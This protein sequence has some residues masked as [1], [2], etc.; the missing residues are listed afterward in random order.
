M[1]ASPAA[2]VP[3]PAAPGSRLLVDAE[4]ACRAALLASLAALEV[5]DCNLLRFHYLH[6][7]ALAPLADMFCT[8]PSAMARQLARLRERIVRDTRRGLAARLALGKPE[9]DRLADIV[10]ARFD[11]VIAR[12]L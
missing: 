12:V 4:A 7:V 3:P 11:H 1:M 6:G 9:L 5:G 10:R 8:P 2:P